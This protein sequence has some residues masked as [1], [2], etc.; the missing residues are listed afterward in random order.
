MLF[1]CSFLFQSSV[2]TPSIGESITMA[3]PTGPTH[4]SLGVLLQAASS[5]PAPS[6]PSPKVDGYVDSL[7]LPL[8][9]LQLHFAA[10]PSV[11]SHSLRYLRKGTSSDAKP[12]VVGK[13]SFLVSSEREMAVAISCYFRFADN[14]STFT[15]RLRHSLQVRRCVAPLQREGHFADGS[16]SA[17]LSLDSNVMTASHPQTL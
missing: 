3:L 1:G 8:P 14:D 9:P 7:R 5:S 6:V 13:V 11:T 2:L 16:V 10:A 17:A 15:G 12:A 4:A